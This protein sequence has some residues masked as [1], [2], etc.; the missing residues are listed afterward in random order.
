MTLLTTV[1]NE[2]HHNLM[3]H[4]TATGDLTSMSFSISIYKI[5]NF[6]LFPTILWY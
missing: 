5:K 3:V 4:P 1:F 6:S 2:G